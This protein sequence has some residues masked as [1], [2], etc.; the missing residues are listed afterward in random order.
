LPRSSTFALVAAAAVFAA[1]IGFSDAAESSKGAGRKPPASKREGTTKKGAPRDLSRAEAVLEISQGG[2]PLG[3]VVFRLFWDI[4]PEHVRN[5]VELSEKGFYDGTHFHSVIPG[6]KVQGGDPLSK[7]PDRSRH[8]QGF[9]EDAKGKPKFLRAE[10]SSRP[11]L[12][13]TLSMARGTNLDSASSQFFVCLSDQPRLDH[14]YTVFGEVAEGLEL[15]DRIA[16]VPRDGRDNPI[17]DVVVRK[18]EIRVAAP[19][20]SPASAPPSSSVGRSPSP[21]GAGKGTPPA[22]GIAP[23]ASSSGK[24]GK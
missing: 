10:L 3:R 14:Q 16:G 12:R 8:G 24:R 15:L 19:S 2:A 18:V 17:T 5:F 21:T 11:H 20:P 7:L 9:V 6:F 22:S 4:A 13:G 23:P 1:G